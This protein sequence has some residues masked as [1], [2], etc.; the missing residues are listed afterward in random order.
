MQTDQT[1]KQTATVSGWYKEHCRTSLEEGGAAPAV[2]SPLC[3][4]AWSSRAGN[5][6]ADGCCQ[7]TL[8]TAQSLAAVIAVNKPLFAWVAFSLLENHRANPTTAERA[9]SS[10]A[11]LS[12][13]EIRR[14]EMRSGVTTG[15]SHVLFAAS[16]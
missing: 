2:L 7:G 9:W 6:L 14:A 4:R 13:T 12:V 15:F 11:A 3:G 1:E 16:L 8:S 5:W 10:A